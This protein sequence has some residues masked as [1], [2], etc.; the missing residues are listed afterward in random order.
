MMKDLTRTKKAKMTR[1]RV[2]RWQQ[3]RRR[4][5]VATANTMSKYGGWLAVCYPNSYSNTQI[6]HWDVKSRRL[7]HQRPRASVL[8]NRR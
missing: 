6:H 7:W 1:N 8:F 5:N 4:R 2:I 3:W